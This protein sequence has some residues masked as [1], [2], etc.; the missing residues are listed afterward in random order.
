MSEE[1]SLKVKVQRLSNRSIEFDV[2]G[3]DAS[4]ANAFRRIMIAEVYLYCLFSLQSVDTRIGPN[5]SY[6]KRIRL[7]EHV[8]D[9][10]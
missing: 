9:A 8:C 2:V 4:I 6:R 10:R 3:I 5:N 1:K 7:A